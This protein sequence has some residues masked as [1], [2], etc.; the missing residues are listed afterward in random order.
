MSDPTLR[1]YTDPVIRWLEENGIDLCGRSVLAAFS[2]GADSAAMLLLLA[3]LRET[4]RFTLAAAHVH[5][6]L[7]GAEADRDAGFCDAFCRRHAI[8][9]T[10]LRGDARAE[11]DERGTGV[12]DGARILRYAL[13]SAHAEKTGA[14]LI[15]TAH[16]ADDNL[17][18]VLLHLTRGGALGGLCGIPPRNGNVIRPIL[19]L[20]REDTEAIVRLCGETC[21]TDSTN[22][23]DDYA[24]NRIRHAVTPVLR[25][26]NPNAARTVLEN[27]AVLRR[28]DA[29][30]DRLAGIPTGDTLL[31]DRLPAEPV[32]RARCLHGWAEANGLDPDRKK[33]ELM[34]RLADGADPSGQADLGMGIVCRREYGLLR[35]TKGGALPPEDVR[36]TAGT[37]NWGRYSVTSAVQNGGP[38]A[39]VY[40]LFNHC[41]VNCATITGELRIRSRREGD[42]F[43]RNA[44]S[45]TK[46]LREIFIDRKVPRADRPFIPV[47]ADDAGIL[48][49]CGIGYDRSRPRF[50]PAGEYVHI[51]FEAAPQPDAEK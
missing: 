44:G 9:F 19:C 41:F 51:C 7:R 13:L 27:G 34:L 11:A 22:D 39:N 15:A 35:M 3:D 40:K 48:W 42:L 26:L 47:V 33:T 17:E 25:E 28:E 38:P 20:R 29:L 32:L 10:L 31:L 45:G 23:S 14:D 16:T 6:G 30:L 8:P 43:T 36:V 37:A 4:L 12:E 21:V 50:D 46:P 18:T 5:H 24:R 2:G 1:P 49:V